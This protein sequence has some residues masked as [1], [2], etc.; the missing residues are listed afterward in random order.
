MRLSNNKKS[1]EMSIQL[2]VIAAI[3]LLLI[4]VLAIIVAEKLNLLSIGTSCGGFS[5]STCASSC[6]ELGA[7][8]KQMDVNAALGCKSGKVCC[9]KLPEE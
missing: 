2:I 1:A 5:D 4:A 7:D 3:T 8:Y 9:V 6:V